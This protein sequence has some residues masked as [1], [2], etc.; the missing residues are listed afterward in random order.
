MVCGRDGPFCRNAGTERPCGDRD[1]GHRGAAE[2]Q[3]DRARRY[4][5]VDSTKPF[6]S[7][8][9]GWLL[10][11]E[12]ITAGLVVG[13]LVTTLGVVMVS[14]E[15]EA[16]PSSP[17]S[18]SSRDLSSNS[19]EDVTEGLL[20]ADDNG[21][22]EGSSSRS[23]S[24]SSGITITDDSN[25]ADTN[26]GSHQR[27]PPMALA[28]GFALAVAHALLDVGGSIITRLHGG[29]YTNLEVN[30]VR[31][32]SAA[33]IL[34]LGASL[35]RAAGSL[36]LLPGSSRSSSSSGTDEPHQRG[37]TTPSMPTMTSSAWRAVLAG[38]MLGTF[39]TPWLSNAALFSIS[40]PVFATLVSVGPVYSLPLAWIVRR[41]PITP[42]ATLGALLAFAGI[43][44]LYHLA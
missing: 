26:A 29:A 5:L 35:A 42:R 14:L 43:I 1:R 16:A 28:A 4:I 40:Y 38:C 18:S 6:F 31:F 20:P 37:K 15:E 24:L 8:F 44:P 3:D 9:L 2:P 19:P 10:L 12:R 27:T 22:E 21:L 7:G 13:M 25:E 17:S 23:R 11:G 39:F 33:L 36:G 34:A 30:T 41:Q 32:G